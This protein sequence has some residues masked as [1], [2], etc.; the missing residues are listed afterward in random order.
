MKNKSRV[1]LVLLV[2]FAA[3][4]FSS[5]LFLKRNNMGTETLKTELENRIND[6]SGFQVHTE[7]INGN[8]LTGFTLKNINIVSRDGTRVMKASFL[9][10]GFEKKALLKGKIHLRNLY[11]R[12]ARFDVDMV[13]SVLS[14]DLAGQIPDSESFLSRIEFENCSFSSGSS[15]LEV[16]D[17]VVKTPSVGKLHGEGKGTLNGLDFETDIIIVKEGNSFAVEKMD[18]KSGTTL[19]SLSGTAGKDLDLAGKF[20]TPDLSFISRLIPKTVKAR[21]KGGINTDLTIT[22]PFKTPRLEGRLS[23]SDFSVARFWFNEGKSSW[24]FS[25]RTLSFTNIDSHVFGSPVS[26]DIDIIFTGGPLESRMKL[27]GRELDVPDWYT[28]LPWLDFATGRVDNIEVNLK[29]P[30]KKLSGSVSF[31]TVNGAVIEGHPFEKL[32]ADLELKNGKDLNFRAN[33]TWYGANIKG[34]GS[35]CIVKPASYLDMSFE[36]KDLDIHQMKSRYPVVGSLDLQGTLAGKAVLKGN[37]NDLKISGSFGSDKARLQDHLLQDLRFS[38]VNSNEGTKVENLEMKWMG[39][40]FK[41]KGFLLDINGK[42]PRGEMTL[43]SPGIKAFKTLDIKNI[44]SSGTFENGILSL[45]SFTSDL[46]GG[47]LN[48][49]GQV[50]FPEGS[51]PCF[52][53]KGNST[54][55][56]TQ[57][58]AAD[59]GVPL[60]IKGKVDSVFSVSGSLSAPEVAA[61]LNSSELIIN[62]LP[63]KAAKASIKARDGKLFIKGMKATLAGS[64][65]R[66]SGIITLLEGDKDTLDVRTTVESLDLFSLTGRAFPNLPVSGVVSTDINIRGA[67]KDPEISMSVSSKTFNLGGLTFDGL[68]L[69]TGLGANQGEPVEYL[70]RTYTGE[71]P[72]EIIGTVAMKK[73]SGLEI[74][75]ESTGRDL[76]AKKLTEKVN[77]NLKSTLQGNFNFTCK[78]KIT[79]SSIT[80]KGEF[81]SSKMAIKGY[82]MN[83]LV[84]PFTLK[85]NKIISQGAS[86]GIYGGKALMEGNIDMDKAKWEMGLTLKDA[87]LARFSL[88]FKEFK[89]NSTGKGDLEIALSG[90]LGKVYLLSGTGSLAL[91]DGT[92]GGFDTLKSLTQDGIL[93][94]RNLNT[95]FNLDGGNVYLLPGSRA[96]AYPEDKVYK[97]LSFSGALGGPHT[98]MDLKC[99]GQINTQ[100]LNA[101]QGVIQGIVRSGNGG[102]ANLLLQDF[103]AGLVGGYSGPDFRKINFELVGTWSK[104]ALY[105][106]EVDNSTT[107]ASSIPQDD[108]PGMPNQKEI[109]FEVSIP[110]GEGTDTSESAGDQFKKQVMENLLKQIFIDEDAINNGSSN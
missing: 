76:D 20:S 110:T 21:L 101:L 69:E 16:K 105:S 37:T 1:L 10:L 64:P 75:F 80:G 60:N 14:R 23:A 98:N 87:D 44:N 90:I 61:T 28:P 108:A 96:S 95:C 82:N 3:G 65:L 52:D 8:P 84:I 92:V 38:F 26:G 54:R 91:R 22:G 18:M 93:K 86:A 62:G 9:K 15:L 42:S 4:L 47:K 59:L 5:V 78:G 31:H 70:L 2:I 103:L 104:P 67:L 24:K 13:T 40:S 107:S 39:S 56:K 88:D 73:G 72:L 48:L 25:D 33:G 35:I 43:S 83:N 11:F 85:G 89:V 66:S 58:L 97:Y 77:G 19:L 99:S 49:S 6:L 41:G 46:A 55:M 53:L 109:K 17:L 45:K 12:D 51:S 27:S 94:Y 68:E 36:T 7:D 74:T 79:G 57:S 102:D 71:I 30:F 34:E 50:K 32:S 100:A 63:L 106:L 81:T 29:G